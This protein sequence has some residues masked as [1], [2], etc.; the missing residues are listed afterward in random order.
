MIIA[1]PMGI[2]AGLVTTLGWSLFPHGSLGFRAMCAIHWP[3]IAVTGVL[4]KTL[5]PQNPEGGLGFVLLLQV[6]YWV[7]LSIGFTLLI[8]WLAGKRRGDAGS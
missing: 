6:V 7:L 1:V 8:Y 4:T 2:T 3:V 5:S